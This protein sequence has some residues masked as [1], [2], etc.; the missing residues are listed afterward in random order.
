M[1]HHN[2]VLSVLANYMTLISFLVWVISCSAFINETMIRFVTALPFT[3]RSVIAIILE[4]A[5]ANSI[6][7][8]T[9]HLLRREQHPVQHLPLKCLTI[10]II[11]LIL[12]MV[13]TYIVVWLVF[14]N[15]FEALWKFSILLILMT[16][17]II[18]CTRFITI[19]LGQRVDTFI[20]ETRLLKQMI[21]SIYLLVFT[22]F[23]IERWLVR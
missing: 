17:I 5:I 13:S 18:L 14:L 10:S 12:A 22:V 23:F 8:M 4:M 2:A 15:Q 7:V 6:G 9:K 20:K 3:L 11:N 1:R 19:H 16:L 21:T